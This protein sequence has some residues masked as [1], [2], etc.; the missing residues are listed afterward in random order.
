MAS[1]CYV[2]GHVW[3]SKE[4]ARRGVNIRSCRVE[5]IPITGGGVRAVGAALAG[6]ATA[7]DVR[8]FVRAVSKVEDV[9]G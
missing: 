3:P 6:S 7:T 1:V 5:G 2:K 8:G 4:N 9:C